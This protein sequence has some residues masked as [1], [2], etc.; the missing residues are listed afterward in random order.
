[1]VCRYDGKSSDVLAPANQMRNTMILI[2]VAAVAM[3]M[4]VAYLVLRP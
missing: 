4:I 1:M 3:G 2:T